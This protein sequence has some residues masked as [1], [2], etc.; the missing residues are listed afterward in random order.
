MK[1][2]QNSCKFTLGYVSLQCQGGWRVSEE[3]FWKESSLNFINNLK[4]R[5][6]WGKMGDDGALA[7]QFLNG[8][9][10]PVGGAA[11]DAGGAIFDGSFVNAS[12]QRDWLIQSI[13]WIEAKTF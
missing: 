11:Y 2:L 10:Y 8:Y 9:T 7:Y 3:K 1:V 13:S 6:S 12:Q 5:A 4:I